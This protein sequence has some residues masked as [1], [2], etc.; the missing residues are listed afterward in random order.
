VQ[1][2]SDHPWW[3]TTHYIRLSRVREALL[4]GP[5]AHQ[6]ADRNE[7]FQIAGAVLWREAGCGGQRTT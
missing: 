1:A 4:R 7:V 3:Q 2:Y 5:Q 6:P